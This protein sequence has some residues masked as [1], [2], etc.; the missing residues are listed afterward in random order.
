MTGRK[1]SLSK[2]KNTKIIQCMVCRPKKPDHNTI[3]LKINNR[4]KT[5]K[6]KKK[7]S[8]NKTIHSSITNGSKKESKG[9]KKS[10]LKS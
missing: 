10:F 5:G 9:G 8:G 3:K 4:R 2:F 6:Y 1:M 7:K